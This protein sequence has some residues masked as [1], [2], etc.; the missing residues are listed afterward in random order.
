MVEG[1]CYFNAIGFSTL[2]GRPATGMAQASAIDYVRTDKAALFDLFYGELKTAPMIRQCP[3]NMELKLHDV[4][5]FDTHDI[6]I[7]RLVQTHADGSVLKAGKID[8]AKLRPLL[9]DM[10]SVQYW[11]LGP[12]VGKCWNVGKT[13][14]A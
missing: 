13:L 6:F 3:V 2:R 5:D 4:L 14:K 1:P 8:I 9:F 11:R 7:G 10:A 12:P